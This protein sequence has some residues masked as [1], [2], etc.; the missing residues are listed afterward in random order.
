VSWL[1]NIEGLMIRSAWAWTDAEYTDEFINA[2]GQ[3][4]DGETPVLSSDF[5]GNIGF[6]YDR[7]LTGI[8]RW[9]LSV[10]ARYDSGYNISA[11]LDPY[12]QDSYWLTD[13][14]LTLYSEDGRY[15]VSLIGLN[16]GDEIIAQGAGAR[17]GAC[18]QVDIGNPDPTAVCTFTTANNQDQVTGTSLGQQFL[19]RAR[20]RL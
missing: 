5:A 19:L 1:P 10:D 14:N 7:G 8:W 13:A 18:G 9:S 16:L 6:T 15:E 20:F 2:T 17:P 12:E 11:T 4:L 3:D